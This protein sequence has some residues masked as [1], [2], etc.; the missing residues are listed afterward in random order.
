MLSK[1]NINISVIIATFNRCTSLA[2]TL[3]SLARQD[4]LGDVSCEIIVIDNNSKDK[5]KAVTDSFRNIFQGEL[6][7]FF[8]ARQ[9]KSFA[10]NKGISEAKGDI[11]AFTDDDVILP[12][13]WIKEI[14]K[15]FSDDS[16]NIISGRVIPL[17]P[18]RKPIW[19]SIEIKEPVV[20]IDHGG[21][22]KKINYAIGCNMAC[23]KEVFQKINFTDFRRT[24]D[25]VFSKLI[26]LDEDIFY[27][28]DIFVYHN[29]S[30]SRT[31]LFYFLKW[32]FTSGKASAQFDLNQKLK[33]PRWVFRKLFFDFMYL[34]FNIFELKRAMSAI[35]NISFYSGYLYKRV[36]TKAEI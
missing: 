27:I 8:E 36:R 13:N 3:E 32:Y 4:G 24:K 22:I 19:Y 12:N 28:P 18:S 25:A 6:Q 5:T 2:D 1:V 30:L 17:W 26:K 20:D 16:K 14:M 33:L 7:Y 35:C 29:I 11:I 34:A 10:L 9:G 15:Q 21:A 31:K 23:R